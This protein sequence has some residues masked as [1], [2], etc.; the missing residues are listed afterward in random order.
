M[1]KQLT[2]LLTATLLL[3]SLTGCTNENSS[4][5]DNSSVADTNS[6]VTSNYSETSESVSSTNINSLTPLTFTENDLELQKTLE[7]LSNA[8]KVDFWFQGG[9]FSYID[10]VK[11]IEIA[12]EDNNSNT[13]HYIRLPKN[14]KDGELTFPYSY[15]ELK[16]TV[17]QYFTSNAT[18]IYMKRYIKGSITSEVGDILKVKVS[19]KGLDNT[20]PF[21]LELNGEIYQKDIISSGKMSID[22]P[23]AKVKQKGDN[24][25]V[26]SYLR[27]YLSDELTPDLSY[28]YA[29]PYAENVQ[30]GYLVL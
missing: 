14:L 19:G 28:K 26:F 15:E 5:A 24:I 16:K 3:T 13:L 29:E 1:K 7:N 11:Q 23:T 9:A 6:S 12:N 8:E 27:T 21:F 18:E 20:A 30:T 25:I 22:I 17:N 2:T 10:D 4:T